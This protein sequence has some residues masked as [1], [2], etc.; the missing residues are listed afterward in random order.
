MTGE[1]L[2]RPYRPWHPI[3]VRPDNQMPEDNREI[4]KADCV[5]IQAVAAGKASEEQQKRAWAAILFISGLED[6][7][8]MP[9]EHGGERE[10]GFASGKQ[11]VGF[12]LRKL[13]T[14]PLNFL[15]G[16]ANER[17]EHDDRRNGKAGDGRNSS[18]ARRIG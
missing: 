9:E 18:R 1:K 14:F 11:F 17:R 13:A 8:W 3:Q 5:A 12:Q 2:R 7:P 15:T 6:L 4:R 10:T 16:E